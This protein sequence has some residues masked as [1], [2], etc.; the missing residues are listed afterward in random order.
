MRGLWSC[1]IWAQAVEYVS[2]YGHVHL[3]EKL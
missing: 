2:V 1:K 3:S